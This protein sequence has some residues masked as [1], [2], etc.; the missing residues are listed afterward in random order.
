MNRSQGTAVFAWGSKPGTSE[1]AVL[2]PTAEQREVTWRYTTTRPAEGWNGLDFDAS[3]W[4]QGSAPF[5]RN[6][7]HIGRNPR[8]QWKAS[9]LWLRREID[10]P[11]GTWDNLAVAIHYDEAPEIYV[12][13]RLALRLDGYNAEYA[14][15][16]LDREAVRLLTP[17][18]HVLAVHC[19][20]TVGGQFIDLGIVTIRQQGSAQDNKP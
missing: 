6:E 12:D 20:Q 3:A 4:P 2:I 1:P 19:H 9:D 13:G 8:T 10:M 18:K 14:V 7:P 5:G 15:I 16:P 17:G 11:A